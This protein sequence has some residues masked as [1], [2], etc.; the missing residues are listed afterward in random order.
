LIQTQKKRKR[1]AGRSDNWKK[2]SIFFE[3]PYWKSVLLRHNLDVMHIE[4]NISESV[5]GTLLDIEGKTK[6]TLKSRLDIQEMRI[7]KSLHPIKSGDKY[8]LPPASYTMSKME[9]I[10]F[11][12]LIKEVKFP[13][14]Y[15]SNISRCVKEARLLG[16]KSHDH[17]VLFQRIIPLIIKEILP[18][19]AYDPLIELSLFFTD[20][21]AKELHVEKLDQLD[22][23]IRITISKLERVFLP[24]F[25]DVMIHLAIHLANEAK[26]AGPVQYRWMYY[27]ERLDSYSCEVFFY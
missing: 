15:S 22:K 4:K 14:A 26:L 16:L 1:D 2:K 13:D 10:Q 8:I 21:C 25:F 7:K 19:D 27:I 6:D 9:K 20:L 12:N 3:L 18:K 5:L 23:S 17:H 11:C 24:T